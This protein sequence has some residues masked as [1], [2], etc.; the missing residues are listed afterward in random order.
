MKRCRL[1]RSC[2]LTSQAIQPRAQMSLARPMGFPLRCSGD[3]QRSEQAGPVSV[4][5][6]SDTVILNSALASGF[7]VEWLAEVDG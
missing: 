3:A 2:E 1:A 5:V 6:L 4:S 7:D